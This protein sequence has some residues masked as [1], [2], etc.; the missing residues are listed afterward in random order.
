MRAGP[1]SGNDGGQSHLW[2]HHNGAVTDTAEWIKRSE[3]YNIADI[4]A[5]EDRGAYMYVAGDCTRAYSPDKLACFTRQIVF[6]RPGTFVI[7]DRVI[8]KKPNF[9]KTWLLQAM[10]VP[11]KTGQNL[12]ITNGKGRLFVQTLLPSNPEMRLVEGSDLY[13][14]GG[15]TYP[16]QADTGPAPQCRIEISPGESRNDDYFLNVLT[17][18]NAGTSSVEQA[19]LE[20]TDQE[21]TVVIG[22]AKISFSTAQVASH[23]AVSGR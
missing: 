23:I 3:L 11:S 8:S 9:K 1:V 20:L 16:P 5:F 22:A 18:T 21:V 7:F 10:K 19:T 14:Y 15:K 13:S 4:L 17:A 12:V 2:P 6:L